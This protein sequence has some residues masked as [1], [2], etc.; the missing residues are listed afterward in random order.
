MFAST[1]LCSFNSVSDFSFVRLEGERDSHIIS[2][3]HE[4]MPVGEV[5]NSG[6]AWKQV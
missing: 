3:A 5:N 1:L 4:L 2:S 6:S